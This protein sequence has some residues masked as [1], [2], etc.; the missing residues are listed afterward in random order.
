MEV[1]QIINHLPYDR[2]FALKS[3]EDTNYGYLWRDFFSKIELK[4][5]VKISVC[6]G[7]YTQEIIDFLNG[8][9]FQFIPIIEQCGWIKYKVIPL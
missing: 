3:C 9:G 4:F 2:A 8:N 6:D 5:P 1:M 7:E